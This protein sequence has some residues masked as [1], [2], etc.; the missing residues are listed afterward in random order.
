MHNFSPPNFCHATLGV[1][2][3]CV[4]TCIESKAKQSRT[5]ASVSPICHR[6][7]YVCQICTA[8]E[9]SRLK[10]FADQRIFHG[11]TSYGSYLWL[12]SSGSTGA[13]SFFPQRFLAHNL[14]TQFH[15]AESRSRDYFSKRTRFSELQCEA[16]PHLLAILC[17]E[18]NV[19]ET[20]AAHLATRPLEI[21][22]CFVSV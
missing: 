18:A 19:D 5:L 17:R 9:T 21:Y 20:C 13:V 22:E 16:V 7:R 4:R 3:K 11:R 15:I 2:Y 1:V 6:T 12:R 8:T 14:W 10:N